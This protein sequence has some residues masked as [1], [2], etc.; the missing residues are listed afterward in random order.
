MIM[1]DKI[2]VL[3][4]D[5]IHVLHNDKIQSCTPQYLAQLIYQVLYAMYLQI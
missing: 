3:H 2:R 5:K 1:H 4:N